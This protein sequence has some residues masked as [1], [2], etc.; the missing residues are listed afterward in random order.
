MRAVRDVVGEIIKI[1]RDSK[2]DESIR[3]NL[4]HLV[5]CQSTVDALVDRCAALSCDDFITLIDKVKAKKCIECVG[6]SECPCW[7]DE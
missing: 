1:F 5:D 3:A 6:K 2:D 4:T 7:G